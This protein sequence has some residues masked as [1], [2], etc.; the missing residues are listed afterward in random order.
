MNWMR[1][2]GTSQMCTSCDIRNPSLC[3]K[4]LSSK[5]DAAATQHVLLGKTSIGSEK[6]ADARTPNVVG[7]H[8]TA[9]VRSKVAEEGAA[10]HGQVDAA[11]PVLNRGIRTNEAGSAVDEDGATGSAK[12][13]SRSERS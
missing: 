13:R 9:V 11:V 5:A 7:T 1:T 3:M 4:S 10:E 8:C 12:K 6:R 2:G